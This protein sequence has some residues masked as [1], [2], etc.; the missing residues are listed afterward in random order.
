MWGGYLPGRAGWRAEKC[1]L[2]FLQSSWNAGILQRCAQANQFEI[3]PFP[4]H[5]RKREYRKLNIP[6]PGLKLNAEVWIMRSSTKKFLKKI[7]IA[8]IAIIPGILGLFIGYNYGEID[9]QIETIETLNGMQN[10][11]A[12]N[13]TINYYSDSNDYEEALAQ[14]VSDVNDSIQKSE[15]LIRENANLISINED[16]T[17]KNSDL[18]SNNMQLLR[19]ITDLKLEI[20][21]LED[22]LSSM[23]MPEVESMHDM[24]LS[25]AILV[26][27]VDAHGYIVNSDYETLI[28]T[29]FE[30]S[31]IAKS[32]GITYDETISICSYTPFDVIYNLEGKYKTLAGQICFDDISSASGGFGSAFSGEAKILFTA[33]NGEKEELSLSATDF[34]KDFSI[35][36]QDAEKLTISFSFP[37]SNNVFNNFNKYFNIVNAYLEI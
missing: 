23:P 17:N 26:K 15:N 12:D 30:K 24:P 32:G 3:V 37:Y 19:E 29:G 25:A 35:N 13:V 11:E 22:E 10:I 33:D 20:K 6:N 31:F 34:P 4:C 2:I 9:T 36:I 18:T 7:L 21:R 16:L 1:R 14:I 5:Y 8:I 28:G 27:T